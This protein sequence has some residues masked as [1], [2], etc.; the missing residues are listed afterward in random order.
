M[1]STASTRQQIFTTVQSN[2]KHQYALEKYSQR[3]TAELQEIDKLLAAADIGDYEDDQPGDIEIQGASRTSGPIPEHELLNPVSPFYSEATKRFN[4]HTSTLTHAMRPKELDTLTEAVTAELRR[5][6]VLEGQGRGSDVLTADVDKVNWKTIAEKVSDVSYFTR[7]DRECRTK[8][9]GYHR[10][11]ICHTSWSSDELRRL[12]DIVSEK[13][14]EYKL[15]WVE[16]AQE[17]GTSRTPMD[18]MRHGRKTTQHTWTPEA[19]RKL[20]E[21]VQVY[22]IENW[23]LVALH[24][25]PNVSSNQCQMRYHRSLDPSLNKSPWSRAED[26]R[27]DEIISVLGALNWPEVARHMPGR[28]NEMC[29]ERYLEGNKLKG[30]VKGKGKAKA[31][32]DDGNEPLAGEETSEAISRSGWTKEQDEE[33]LRMVGEIGNKWQ[34]ISAAMGEVHTN[35]Q[36]CARYNKLKNSVPPTESTTTTD[37]APDRHSRSTSNEQP[38]KPVPSSRPSTNPNA[39]PSIASSRSSRSLTFLPGESHLPI[40]QLMPSSITHSGSSNVS[41]TEDAPPSGHSHASTQAPA[42]SRPKPKP[43]LKAKTTGSCEVTSTNTHVHDM[44]NSNEEH[45]FSS[46]SASNPSSGVPPP[47]AVPISNMRQKRSSRRRTITLSNPIAEDLESY[48]DATSVPSSIRS[49]HNQ[50]QIRGWGEEDQG[51]TSIIEGRDAERQIGG[52]EPARHVHGWKA[53]AAAQGPEAEAQ[54]R[55]GEGVVA[56]LVRGWEGNTNRPDDLIGTEGASDVVS[57]VSSSEVVARTV[58]SMGETTSSITS[59]SLKRGRKETN[60]QNGS[61]IGSEPNNGSIPTSGR[62]PARKKGRSRKSTANGSVTLR[63]SSRLSKKS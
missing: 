24:V 46:N 21:A 51:N 54:V 3:L 63:R 57:V 59:M 27:L 34:K 33:L 8:W 52:S 23:A 47:G 36:C 62:E 48:P 50:G 25:S 41:A 10:P 26:E 29:R 14:E 39:H 42:K 5:L 22:G 40:L 30:Q 38:V 7:S 61:S 4:Y 35:V 37:T 6:S 1:L 32:T 15:D 13:G 9:F 19:N 18:C 31:K 55:E 16:I 28:T 45:L 56:G 49:G 2:T 44:Y 11:G 53:E 20:S 43:K 12:K 60:T 17:L 58:G